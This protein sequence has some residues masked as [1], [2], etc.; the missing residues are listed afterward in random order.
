MLDVDKEW[1]RAYAKQAMSDLEAREI[2]VSGCAQKCH[3]LHFLQMAAEKV[4]KAYLTIANGH[5]CVKKKH[6]YVKRNLPIIARQFYSFL[7]NKNSIS[8][9][10]ISEIRRLS[11]EIEVLAP[12]CDHANYRQDN[13][14]YPWI[15]GKGNIKIPCEHN[16]PYINDSSRSIIRL[17][18]LIRTA[19]ESYAIIN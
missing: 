8:K 17:I 7:N 15:D 5:E 12:A 10:E 14:E 13:S 9:W 6:T 18:K 19:S 1:A 3:R 11:N 4:C 16:F 2:L